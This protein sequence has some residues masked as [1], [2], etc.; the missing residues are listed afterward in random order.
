ME[1]A[2]NPVA[3]GDGGGRTDR[4]D[5]AT[6]NIGPEKR[7]RGRP[8]GTPNRPKDN[9]P[10]VAPARRDSE[11]TTFLDPAAVGD[12]LVSIS[13]IGDD[14]AVIVILNRARQKLP[15]NNFLRFREEMARIRLGDKDKNLIKISGIALAKKYPF[16]QKWG[17]E[18]VLILVGVQYSARMGNALRTINALPDLEKSAPVVSPVAPSVPVKP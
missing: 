12:L 13:E 11:N 3:N 10:K 8:P 1:E 16:L 7:G 14:L 15:E 4:P 9:S 5:V 2:A 18:L 17:P 6:V